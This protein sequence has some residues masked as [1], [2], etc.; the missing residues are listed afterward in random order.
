MYYW[1]SAS[2]ESS[3]TSAASSAVRA[4]YPGRPEPIR[5]WL[6][7]LG[8]ALLLAL[9]LQGARPSGRP[10]GTRLPRLQPAAPPAGRLLSRT[11]LAAAA[12]ALE[13]DGTA[14]RPRLLDPGSTLRH[15]Y[16]DL[17]C[18]TY[19]PTK[20][21][22][23]Q[24]A[25]TITAVEQTNDGFFYAHGYTDFAQTYDLMAGG[26]QADGVLLQD[27]VGI[28]C[29]S[30]AP[31]LTAA[32]VDWIEFHFSVRSAN[33]YPTEYV[34]IVDMMDSQ[35]IPH[36]Q[37]TETA[38]EE[39]FYDARGLWGHLYFLDALSPGAYVIDLGPQAV[40]DLQSRVGGAGWFGVGMAADGWDLAGSPGQLVFNRS[41]GGGDAVAAQRPYFRVYYNAPPGAFALG[42]PGNGAHTSDAT[43]TLT[44]AAACDPNYGDVVSYTLEYDVSPDFTA[45]VSVPGIT[46]TTFTPSVPLAASHT[47]W[48]RIRAVDNRQNVRLCE[49]A[50]ALTIDALSAVGET[51]PPVGPRLGHPWPNPMSTTLQVSLRP[52][53]ALPVDVYDVQGRR[54]AR[55]T[56]AAAGGVLGWDGRGANGAPVPA[57]NYYLVMGH[58]ITREVRSFRLVR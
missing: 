57:G 53:P 58:D 35:T 10:G 34:G 23:S 22:P 19:L 9:S 56:D 45:P 18:D 8:L 43:P 2:Q 5:R 20:A 41:A 29:A 54:V 3:S 6:L 36:S 14:R 46:T 39:W 15:D 12:P 47:Y 21:T 30:L 27:A 42:A 25:S 16:V 51:P 7:L 40:L 24:R 17:P 33:T 13:A 4:R 11:P 32:N 37:S 55:L 50:F 26:L 44:W 1:T 38:W 52:G 49:Q 31:E 48:W 28:A